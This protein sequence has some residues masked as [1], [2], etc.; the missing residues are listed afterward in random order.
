MK[1]CPTCNRIYEDDT[2]VFCL[3]DGTRLSASYGPHVTAREFGARDTN[4]PS[5]L[6]LNSGSASS[7]Q[8]PLRPTIPAGSSF[9][10]PQS[11]RTGKSGGKFWIVLSGMLALAL[12]AVVILLGYSK[13]K[14]GNNPTSQPARVST[15]DATSSNA[16]VDATSNKAPANAD[17]KTQSK[18]IESEGVQWL[19][20][21]WEG[22]GYQSDTSTTWL[23]KLLVR[24]GTYLID[25]PT[26]PCSGKWILAD[27]HSSGATFNE[28][29]TQGTD[30]C[31]KNDHV[32]I[33]KVNDSEI[34]CKYTRAKSRVV[35]PTAVRTRKS[36]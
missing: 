4:P 8:V 6:I 24:D 25:Y 19:E 5:T 29:I 17:Q 2:L 30:R 11:Q 16:P 20:G 7:N 13:W 31:D 27:H 36:K 26:I 18:T 21:S 32:I 1:N 28:V 9:M 10:S 35:I 15:N 12:I 23:V 14:A 22:E 34:S 3:D 33:E